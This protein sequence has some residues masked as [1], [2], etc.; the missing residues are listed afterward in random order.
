MQ[1]QE[2]SF[3]RLLNGDVQYV[4][5]R[6]QRRY[7]WGLPEIER[8]LEDLDTVAQA[9]E[10][11]THYGGTFLTFPEPGG[12]AGIVQKYR[13]VDGQQRLTTVCLLLRCIA[14]ELGQEE[15]IE[16]WTAELICEGRLTNPKLGYE[17]YSKLR[18]Q[19]GDEEEFRNILEGNFRGSGTLF[20]GWQIVKRLI[21]KYE[22]RNLMVGLNRLTVVSIGLTGGEDPQQIFE[23]INATGR[24]LT[25]SEKVKNWLLIGLPDDQQQK[26]HDESWLSIE[27]S[28][29]ASESSNPIDEFLR[30]VLR[31]KTGRVV[32]IDKVYEELRR[33]AVREQWSNRRVELCHELVRLSGIYGQISG[34]NVERN[35]LHK[36]VEHQL[37]HLRL[38]QINVH[39]PL[40]LRLVSELGELQAFDQLA[41]SLKLI[42]IWLTRLWVSGSSFAGL[43]QVFADIAHSS[44]LGQSGQEQVEN[45]KLTIGGF[46]KRQLSI[47][48]DS[49]ILE[50]IKKRKAYGGGATGTSFAIL[51]ELDAANYPI[52]ESIDPRNLTV[53]H[54]LPQKLTEEWV[55]DLGDD[56]E[57][58]HTQYRD[59]L[60]NLTLCGDGANSTVGVATFE[61][62][63]RVYEKSPLAITRKLANETR[64]NEESLDRRARE[65]SSRICSL[66]PWEDLPQESLLQSGL[67]WR[68]DDGEWNN[69]TKGS[70]LVLQIAS[71]LLSLDSRNREKL[72]SPPNSS[73]VF[74]TNTQLEKKHY[75]KIP[76][77]PDS[78]IYPYTR[79]WSA[80]VDRC[81]QMGSRCGVSVEVEFSD[82]PP[83]MRFWNFFKTATGGFRDQ[84]DNYR[85]RF[86][87]FEP[88]N[89]FGDRIRLSTS[90]NGVWMCIRNSGR[91]D[92]DQV[93][94][95]MQLYT[96]QIQLHMKDQ[97]LGTPAQGNGSSKN[98]QNSRTIW[99][100]WKWNIHDEDSWEEAVNWIVDQKV[101]LESII[102]TSDF[103]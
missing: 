55:R 69:V 16:G 4:V 10:G 34:T 84:P 90:N 45:L 47:P 6:W 82:D 68:I 23:S 58:I 62:K 11:A 75:R 79:T 24:P 66:W 85:G 89:D 100:W 20:A 96:R 74:E 9:E 86:I 54:I 22:I 2:T 67:R 1:A 93:N 3:I 39:R 50:G 103:G 51:Y 18:L 29:G 94:L 56:A 60:A 37:N 88:M 61:K 35:Q 99:V 31:W 83:R 19:R 70:D 72:S 38:L 80:S 33:W 63:K 44:L 46:R 42:G 48:T 27:R 92:L 59:S 15:E 26:L 14:D 49:A 17:H 101:R 53:E 25:E 36:E 43:N 87:N 8:L 102:A 30:D 98:T 95:R 65:L 64:W 5:P 41:S 21:R 32:G 97:L 91:T 73:R 28:L 7:S 40:T 77:H 57:S 13:V 81:K 78:M 76:G 52:G 71:S 12:P